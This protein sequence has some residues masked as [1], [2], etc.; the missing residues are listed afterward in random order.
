MNR[1][2]RPFWKETV[3]LTYGLLLTGIAL[4]L[5]SILLKDLRH[6]PDGATAFVRDLGLL[7][8]AVMGGTI[9]HDN[10]LREELFDEWKSELSRQLEVTI[11][12]VSDIATTTANSAHKLFSEKPPQMTGLRLLDKT[13]RNSAVYYSW[14]ITQ[15]PQELFFAGRSI[16]HRID[17]DVRA[18]TETSA[19][20]VLFRRLKEGSKI[21]ILFLDPRITILNRLAEEEGEPKPSL[22]GNVAVSVGICKRL[23]DLINADRHLL[24]TSA[25]LTIRI[26]DQTPYFAY[27][28]QD[29]Q[30]V[31]GF[32]FL[33][34]QGSSSAAYEV[35]DETT[36]LTFRDHFV[37][38]GSKAVVNSVL[39]FDGARGVGNFNLALYEELHSFFKK[40]LGDRAEDFLNGSTSP[41][42]H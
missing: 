1:R 8:A 17:A 27:H 24:P 12:Q 19:E 3:L 10:L 39:E 18:R 4:I 38:I 6:W 5:A 20:E 37:Q 15:Q 28:K 34:M 22:L 2:N 26:Y 16:L 41:A 33:S 13:R 23:Y 7:L 36:K 14:V 31:V 35:I 42:R 32:Y 9:L 21:T 11:P 29:D 40:E 25:Q 30:V